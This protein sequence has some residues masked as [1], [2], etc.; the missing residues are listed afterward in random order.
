MAYTNVETLSAALAAL[1]GAR[2][3]LRPDYCIITLFRREV[4]VR[5]TVYAM[6]ETWGAVTVAERAAAT[7]NGLL[8]EYPN[9]WVIE[10]LKGELVHAVTV[11]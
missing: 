10:N 11:E 9:L 7:V 1:N 6:K 2:R 3:A 5:R 8:R 4:R